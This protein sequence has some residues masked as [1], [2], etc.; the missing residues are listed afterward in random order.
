MAVQRPL[1]PH[2]QVYRPQ[3]T[4][5]L[6]ILHRITGLLLSL[7]GVLLVAWVLI[8][9]QGPDHHAHVLQVAGGGLMKWVVCAGFYVFVFSLV[10]HL[11]NGIRHLAW[12]AGWGLDIP[13]AYRS[14]WA[15]VALSVVFTALL[16]WRAMSGG[17]A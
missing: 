7:G 6:S 4:S 1:S 9:A 8:L 5:T 2:L 11:L 13:S 16:A 15:V 10:Y 14:G 12:D 17:A 3:L